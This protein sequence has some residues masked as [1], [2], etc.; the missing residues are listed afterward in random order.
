MRASSRSPRSDF[1]AETREAIEAIINSM[2]TE[3]KDNANAKKATG[4]G[5]KAPGAAKQWDDMSVQ[6]KYAVMD[7][8]QRR[9]AEKNEPFRLVHMATATIE[10]WRLWGLRE[11]LP[12]APFLPFEVRSRKSMEDMIA[13]MAFGRYQDRA[14]GAPQGWEPDPHVAILLTTVRP[15]IGNVRKPHAFALIRVHVHKDQTRLP[16]VDAM[17]V[18]DLVEKGV[19]TAASGI[20]V[21]VDDS[22]KAGPWPT[23]RTTGAAMPIFITT[24]TSNFDVIRKTKS[25]RPLMF[26]LA[27]QMNQN[28]DMYGV[29]PFDAFWDM[30]PGGVDP[31]EK[32]TRLSILAAC[33]PVYTRR[34]ADKLD[35]LGSMGGHV[36]VIGLGR[37]AVREN[38]LTVDGPPLARLRNY[39]CGMR[40]GFSLESCQYIGEVNNR[41]GAYT[42]L[43]EADLLADGIGA[44][45]T[46]DLQLRCV[47][48]EDLRVPFILNQEFERQ[49]QVTIGLLRDCYFKNQDKDMATLEVLLGD[50][51]AK[52]REKTYEAL[53]QALANHAEGRAEFYNAICKEATNHITNVYRG[54]A[55]SR[56]Y[57]N[58][59]ELAQDVVRCGLD[60]K[61]S[62][63]E[64]SFPSWIDIKV[65]GVRTTHG[66]RMIFGRVLDEAY[67]RPRGTGF[68]FG[69]PAGTPGGYGGPPPGGYGGPVAGMYYRAPG[70]GDTGPTGTGSSMTGGF[71]ANVTPQKHSTPRAGNSDEDTI[72]V[73]RS[74][75]EEPM[76]A[77]PSTTPQKVIPATVSVPP[78]SGKREHS[79]RAEEEEGAKRAKTVEVDE[80]VDVIG[81][82]DKVEPMEDSPLAHVSQRIV[83]EEADEDFTEAVAVSSEEEEESDDPEEEEEEDIDVGAAPGTRMPAPVGGDGIPA[84]PAPQIP[85]SEAGGSSEAI[86]IVENDVGDEE[87]IQIV[88]ETEVKKPKK[89]KTNGAKGD[90]PK[91]GSKRKEKLAR[92]AALEETRR[93]VMEAA[94]KKRPSVHKTENSEAVQL[95]KKLSEDPDSGYDMEAPMSAA[96]NAHMRNTY[97]A[98]HSAKV[99]RLTERENSWPDWVDVEELKEELVDIGSS[100][101]R[102]YG[103][104]QQFLAYIATKPSDCTPE[105]LLTPPSNSTAL[106]SHVLLPDHPS[107]KYRFC[108]YCRYVN[109]NKETFVAHVM[110]D[111]FRCLLICGRCEARPVRTKGPEEEFLPA[112]RSPAPMKKHLEKV[113]PEVSDT[114]PEPACV[115]A[116]S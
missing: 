47:Q 39:A 22:T 102:T 93:Q 42:S 110:A 78:T 50:I 57:K 9:A 99:R 27:Q 96:S 92:K 66:D 71:F 23:D 11:G 13:S 100:A 21:H 60:F 88:D 112:W 35:S 30:N 10:D 7:R 5:K 51:E 26:Y 49:S 72:P 73:D 40:D 6:E 43:H 45:M 24:L 103:K 114:T 53:Q 2:S 38:K 115:Q 86:V 68:L 61:P 95:R 28:K 25:S 89:K 116:R 67:S 97:R 37:K 101:T 31:V 12:T 85:N 59:G 20:L 87:D 46:Y 98:L 55:L 4:S 84:Q 76:F 70:G 107:T 90:K 75:T 111:H 83:E 80:A 14:K 18:L 94:D 48:L 17:K 15:Y 65:A 34:H 52:G 3:D 104:S 64:R 81:D 106:S 82:E 32:D 62:L 41:F 113:H 91:A 44:R 36:L 77:A 74:R 79:P 108:P 69:Q 16:I 33:D 63:S 8:D 1:E 58:I 29:I 54:F 19:N 109:S 56:K 105:G